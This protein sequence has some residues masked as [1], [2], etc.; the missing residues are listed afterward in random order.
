MDALT[1]VLQTMPLH[2]CFLGR[3][4]LSAPWGIR[5]N[6]LPHA[7]FHVVIRGNCWLNVDGLQQ[8]VPLTGGDLV[9]IPQ[10][11]GHSLRHDLNSPVLM[12]EEVLAMRPSDR[13]NIIYFGGGGMAT[14]LVCGYFY[15]EDWGYNPL[16]A[17]LSPL[18]LIKGEDGRAVEWLDATLQFIA[19]ETRSNRPGAETVIT[20]LCDVL[21][22]QS[23]RAFIA[24]LK[25][26]D[27]S[28]LQALKDPNI[29]LAV[30]TIHRYPEVSWTV[31]SLARQ[32]CMSRSAFAASFKSLVGEPP[33]HYLTRVRMH[34]AVSLLRSSRD[35]LK[36]IAEQV[37]Y[38][39][40]AAFSNAF[41]R[42]HGK[43]PG[44]YR[45]EQGLKIRKGI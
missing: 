43:S 11:H 6:S 40:E 2:S 34:K 25:D 42:W 23:V 19:C 17:A 37:G 21:F 18:I 33:L 32:V 38:E 16:L 7:A 45:R 28:W 5:V 10:G 24:N 26:G 30:G 9:V 12:L 13:Q 27:R 31:D 14:T 44:E 35:N 41:K 3:A 22:I 39:S 8:P 29:G 4:E 36:Q 20:R 1:E 15:F